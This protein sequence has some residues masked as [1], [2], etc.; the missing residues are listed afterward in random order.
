METKRL[1]IDMIKDYI[2]NNIKSFTNEE[3]II[4]RIPKKQNVIKDIQSLPNN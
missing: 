2:R 3:V 1:T 4:E